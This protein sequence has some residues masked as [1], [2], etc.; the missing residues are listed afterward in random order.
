MARLCPGRDLLFGAAPAGSATIRRKSVTREDVGIAVAVLSLRPS[1][2]C[3]SGHGRG[4]SL[5]LPLRKVRT[6]R[7]GDNDVR[8]G[9]RPDMP[10]PL[11]EKS[12]HAAGISPL[13]DRTNAPSRVCIFILRARSVSLMAVI[14]PCTAVKCRGRHGRDRTGASAA[15]IARERDNRGNR[16]HCRARRTLDAG[17]FAIRFMHDAAASGPALRAPRYDRGC[18]RTAVRW[19]AAA[20]STRGIPAAARR[21]L[22]RRPDL[23]LMITLPDG[24]I[25]AERLRD[26]SRSGASV[27]SRERPSPRRRSYA[28]ATG[29]QPL[30]RHTP[31]RFRPPASSLPRRNT[32][33]RGC[34]P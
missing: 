14:W 25:I 33:A 11:P 18:R 6:S 21:T 12:D 31:G 32:G 8:S 20:S 30:I 13:L 28:S 2:P 27:I 34:A 10:N 5:K 29:M 1:R 19:V 7:Q 15:G 24:R 22:Q 26:I 17:R 4:G 3:A 23:H 16:H 9:S